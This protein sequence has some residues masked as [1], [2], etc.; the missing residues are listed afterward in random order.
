MRIIT[1]HHKSRLLSHHKMNS[2]IHTVPAVE[3]ESQLSDSTMGENLSTVRKEKGI[4]TRASLDTSYTV[5]SGSNEISS[6]GEREKK[7]KRCDAKKILIGCLFLAFIVYVIVDYSTTRYIASGISIFMEWIESNPAIGLV[8]FI[9][10]YVVCTILFIPASLL[11]LGAGF[12][13]SCMFG[14]GL[15]LL[16]GSLTVFLGA[17]IGAVLAFLIGRYLLRD[18]VKGLSSKYAI[19]EALDIALQE[20]GFRIMLLL[21]LSPIIP[22]NVID[23]LASITAVSFKDYTLALVGIIPGVM[24]YV[25][26]GASAGSLAEGALAKENATITIVVIVVGVVFGIAAV[27]LTSYYAKKELN[28]VIALR[29]AEVNNSQAMEDSIS[30]RDQDDPESDSASYDA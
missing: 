23:Y 9:A 19:F 21:R 16:L 20:K 15:G 26:L 25:F 5:D 17:C 30:T 27:V 18:C 22:F 3:N 10:I 4:A 28:R 11:T 6:E 8:G 12:V 29:E 1:L 7:P 14:L 13:F 2:P 24:L